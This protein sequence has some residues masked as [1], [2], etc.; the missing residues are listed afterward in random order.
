MS[1]L[2]RIERESRATTQGPSQMAELRVRRRPA[3]PARDAYLD[4]KTRIQNRLIADLD[5]TMD[6]TKTENVRRTIEEMY[7]NI[8]AEEHIVLSRA[9]RPRL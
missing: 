3:S 5:P 1:L 6:V 7:Q 2:K 8:L 9:E 4:L